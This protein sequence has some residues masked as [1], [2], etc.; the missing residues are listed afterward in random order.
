MSQERADEVTR[1]TASLLE[2]G[3]IR[4]L[5]YSTWL[6][7]V[8][9]VKKANGKWRMCM[10]Y[11]DL[12]KACPKDSFSLPNIDALVDAAAGYRLKNAGA[13]YQRLMNKVFS[14]LIGK[15][16]EVYVDDI[17]VKT[18]QA[19]DLVG[20]LE[21]VFASLRRHNM[22]LNPLKC[23]FAMETRKFLG[24]MIIQRGVE[25]NPEKCEAIL[26]M[27]IRT[28]TRNQGP[29]YG[30]FSGRS[31]GK[32]S[33]DVEHTVETP[34]G[35][36]YKVFLGGLILAREAGTTRVDVCSD[37]QVV[38]SQING[39]YQARDS[40]LHKYLEKV[41]KL[42]EEFDE[43][44]VQHISRERNT[45]ADLLSKLAS[46][47]PG[48]GNRSLIQGL[49]K[50][51]TVTLH[52]IQATNPLSWL[53]PIIDF[54]EGGK[55][56]DDDKKAKALRREATKYTTIQGQL[57]KKGLNQ[58]LL[59]C[60]CPDQTDYVLPEVHEWCYGHHIRGKALAQKLVRAGYYW[61]SMMSD[62]K[63]FVRKCRRCQENANFHKA[64]AAELSLLM[65]S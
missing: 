2:A 11:S 55:L 35:R 15:T 26:R 19:D 10:D 16:V 24:F 39:T 1:Q 23:A 44:T 6:S 43:V 60:L 21:T 17:L 58:P 27:T 22:R 4:E 14:S 18:T 38:T 42:S 54:L 31:N 57:F 56:P 65:A 40:L 51:P 29:G 25:A 41:K 5:D 28:Q 63:E 53:D 7:N 45:R 3:F 20:D 30:R 9:L 50:E 32:P 59:K 12:N 47:K 8:V 36:K 62:S 33:R 46:T 49:V 64:P 13:T 37:Y 34:C 48:T 61:P 52:I